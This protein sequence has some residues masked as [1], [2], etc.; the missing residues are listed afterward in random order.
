MT[1]RVGVGVTD[2][3]GVGVTDRV[4]FGVTVRA[5][6]DAPDGVMG[7]SDVGA[8]SHRWAECDAP[9]LNPDSP[10]LNPDSP[11]PWKKLTDW[12]DRFDR[13]AVK[14][15]CLMSSSARFMSPTKTAQKKG[16]G[17]II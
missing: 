6:V 5:E 12:P 17:L 14:G 4:G 3:A 11:S 9:F 13:I 1:D 15:A 16:I 8:P 2:L 7:R 10:F